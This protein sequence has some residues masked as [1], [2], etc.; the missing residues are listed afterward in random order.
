LGGD[1]GVPIVRRRPDSPAAKAYREIASNM[2]A[3]LSIQNVKA[4]APADVSL[5]WTAPL[6]S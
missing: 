1:E 4:A 5:R 6:K 3:Q 2:A